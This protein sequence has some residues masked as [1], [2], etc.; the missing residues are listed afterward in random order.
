MR[1]E[2]WKRQGKQNITTTTTK[3][4]QQQQ[5]QVGEGKI[6]V[7]NNE[8]RKRTGK[9]ARVSAWRSVEEARVTTKN[10][11]KTAVSDSEQRK[12]TYRQRNQGQCVAKCGR[13]KR[14][15]GKNKPQTNKQKL[16]GATM[17]QE[18]ELT[19]KGASTG[20]WRSMEGARETEQT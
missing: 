8:P 18:R 2:V 5:Q 7:S 3:Q 11:Q 15:N 10:K 12:R 19:G 17:S 14:N 16:Q 1:G 4:Q 9:G 6:S 20:A 13:G